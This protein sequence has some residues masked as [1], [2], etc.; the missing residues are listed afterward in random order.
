M[1]VSGHLVPFPDSGAADLMS[2]NLELWGESRRFRSD[3][4]QAH[5]SEKTPTEI[6][7]LLN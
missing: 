4:C 5:V 7:D 1:K 6:T 2:N 3:Q